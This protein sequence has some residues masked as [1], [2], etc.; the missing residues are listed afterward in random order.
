VVRGGSWN[1]DQVNAR[2]SYRNDN[3]PDNRNNNAGLR[4]VRSSHILNPP[5]GAAGW[6]SLCPTVASL[7]TGIAGTGRASGIGR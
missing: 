4:V 1:N 3:A 2:A 6:M 7:L 5:Y